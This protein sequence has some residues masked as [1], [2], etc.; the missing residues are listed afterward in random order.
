VKK[1]PAKI[2]VVEDDAFTRMMIVKLL[3][4]AHY[5]VL[6]AGDGATAVSLVKDEQPGVAIMDVTM[7]NMGGLAALETIRKQGFNFPVLMLSGHGEVD[8]RLRGL[9][10]GADDYMAKPFDGRE[11]L[12]RVAALL[13]RGTVAVEKPRVLRRHDVVID[14][15]AKRATRAGSPLPLT[16]T[17]YAI[18]DALVQNQGRPLSRERLLELVWGYTSS[19]TTRTVETHI[20]RLRKKLGDSVDAA[21]WIQNLQGS[22]YVL[23]PETEEDA[24]ELL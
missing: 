6:E 3:E 12:A 11:L 10:L 13:R 22:G 20:W 1:L 23:S 9:R 17:E 15:A 16:A 4:G 19:S 2:L 5:R 24:E 14:L 7:P 18:L 21:G 8:H